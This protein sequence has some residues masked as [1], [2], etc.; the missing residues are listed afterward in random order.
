MESVL[1]GIL[2]GRPSNMH[3]HNIDITWI[4]TT[5][6]R[7]K[8]IVLEYCLP[9]IL[10]RDAVLERMT[11]LRT[12]RPKQYPHANLA[13]FG[14]LVD[15][16]RGM[17]SAQMNR[18]R[19]RVRFGIPVNLAIDLKQEVI[20][21]LNSYATADT[22]PKYVQQLLPG[23]I[24]SVAE[25][26]RRVVS[27]DKQ[28]VNEAARAKLAEML[29]E[30]ERTTFADSYTTIVKAVQ[31]VIDLEW[32]IMEFQQPDDVRAISRDVIRQLEEG[33]SAH[34][35]LRDRTTFLLMGDVSGEP[36]DHKTICRRFECL[37]EIVSTATTPSKEHLANL[38]DFVARL[39]DTHIMTNPDDGS[40][41][42]TPDASL[43]Q[44]VLRGMQAG[45]PRAFY[46]SYEKIASWERGV[47]AKDSIVINHCLPAMMEKGSVQQKVAMLLTI[48]PA[49]YS[50]L[51]MT[52][53]RAMVESANRSRPSDGFL[54]AVSAVL[55][56]YSS[57]YSTH[58]NK[59][60]K[61]NALKQTLVLIRVPE[62]NTVGQ[63]RRR[64]RKT[65]S[66]RDHRRRNASARRS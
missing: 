27:R 24:Q 23:M 56:A 12:I 2:A 57:A 65:E 7:R 53:F 40:P 44:C 35:M 13:T 1:D 48:Q 43:I 3:H 28:A 41:L 9:D 30:Y 46:R 61:I 51:P 34:S 62:P 45:R 21:L 63:A 36:T 10:S 54:E 14:L 25:S 58:P 5:L 59:I 47:V 11:M 20:E 31:N 37:M 66:E 42:P 50:N 19:D 8:S 32:S 26:T 60:R 18:D 15:A 17:P 4:E 38:C 39:A 22:T 64:D 33:N 16:A 52:S 29:A 49:Q 6:N 55:T